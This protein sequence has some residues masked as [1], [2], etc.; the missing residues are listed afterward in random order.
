MHSPRS[1]YETVAELSSPTPQNHH[2]L[3]WCATWDSNPETLR[4]KLSTYTVP[5]AAQSGDANGTRTRNTKGLKDPAFVQ[6]HWHQFWRRVWE[7]NPQ[8]PAEN[9]TA[10]PPALASNQDRALHPKWGTPSLLGSEGLVQ[11]LGVEPSR[12]VRTTGLQPA[13]GPSPSNATFWCLGQ[14]IALVS[15]PLQGR[16]N[17]SQLPRRKGLRRLRQRRAVAFGYIN[18]SILVDLSRIELAQSACKADPR[19]N[20]QARSGAPVAESNPIR[21]LCRSGLPPRSGALFG[22]PSETRTRSAA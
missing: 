20:G 5:S 17:L 18:R 10:D 8:L 2:T 15:R 13:R 6:L 12:P 7:S 4:S 3:K 1:A 14:S 19:P 11:R 16:A 22:D 9:R 21:L